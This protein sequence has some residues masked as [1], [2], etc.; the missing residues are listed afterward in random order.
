M[1]GVEPFD[2]NN[3]IPPMERTVVNNNYNTN[4]RRPSTTKG[5]S[6]Y[7]PL[8]PMGATTPNIQQTTTTDPN[9]N[10]T[11]NNTTNT[12]NTTTTAYS[13]SRSR[14]RAL[15]TP[16]PTAHAPSSLSGIASTISSP[17]LS[18]GSYGEPRRV[19]QEV[20]GGVRLDH[21]RRGEEEEILPPSYAAWS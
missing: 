15:P 17:P 8:S 19:R 10:T 11:S 3:G 7:F 2:I 20:D 21:W 12:T 4:G 9:T 5:R 18:D 1:V 16:P 13:S 14:S 6:S